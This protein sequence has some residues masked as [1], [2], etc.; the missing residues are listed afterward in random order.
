MTFKK[1]LLLGVALAAISPAAQANDMTDW[2]GFYLGG[3]AGYG[4]AQGDLSVFSHS[5]LAT[6]RGFGT[7][8]FEGFDDNSDQDGGWFGGGHIGFNKQDGS[9]VFGLELDINGG[10]LDIGKASAASLAPRGDEGDFA[11]GWTSANAEVDWYG[12]LRARVGYAHGPILAYLTGGVAFGEVNLNG[13][14]DLATSFDDGDDLRSARARFS[15]S[16]R[17]IGWTAGFGIDYAKSPNVIIGISYQYVDL[18]D[19]SSGAELYEFRSLGGG[20]F[21][22][23]A[24]VAGDANAD[25]SFHTLQARISF[26]LHGE[27]EEPLK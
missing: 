5:F 15:D 18:G 24:R 2:S 20:K 3:Q 21:S 12:T 14:V 9:I 26:K 17:K 10:A 19:V 25:A 7:R 16:S 23:D 1:T 4:F 13:T 6:T 8:T 27:R 11:A 22:D